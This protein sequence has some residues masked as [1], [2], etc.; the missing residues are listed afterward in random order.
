MEPQEDFLDSDSQIPGQTYTLLSFVSPE[1]ILRS[2]EL[3]MHQKFLETFI[4]NYDLKYADFESK[5][6]DFLYINSEKLEEEFHTENDFKTTV[7]GVKVRGTYAN[8]KEA[9]FRAKK[10]QKSDPNF[11]VFIG[12]VG[13]WLPWDPDTLKIDDQEY[14]EGELNNLVKKYRE[15]KEATD[16]HFSENVQYAKDQAHIAAQKSSDSPPDPTSSVEE[17]VNVDEDLSASRSVPETELS[18]LE[19]IDPWL[20]RKST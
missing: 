9:Q 19:A 4:K 6:K 8:M 20:A 18:S 16:T 14:A 2:K 11:N 13:F 5:Y 15:N 3:W 10:L 12:Q 17:V 1:K 7:R